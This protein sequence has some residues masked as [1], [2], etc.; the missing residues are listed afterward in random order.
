MKATKIYAERIK[1]GN[2]VERKE[3]GKAVFDENKISERKYNELKRNLLKECPTRNKGEYI[4]MATE[5]GR[6]DTFGG[7]PAYSNVRF[8]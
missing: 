4:R 3:I 2:V 5:D 6:K 1:N 7:Y 8:E